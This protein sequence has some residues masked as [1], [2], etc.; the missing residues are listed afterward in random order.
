MWNRVCG[1]VMDDF[2]WL[3]WWW[4]GIFLLILCFESQQSKVESQ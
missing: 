1:M 2:L 4:Y 3:G